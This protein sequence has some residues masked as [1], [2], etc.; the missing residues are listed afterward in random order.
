MSV[1]LVILVGRLGK[2]P[3]LTYTQSG[4]PRCRFSLATSESYTNNAGER[5]EKTDWHNIICWG[6]QAEPVSK[7]L[8]KGKEC[9]I[10]GKI[11][12][13]SWDDPKS[14][15]KKYMTEINAKRVVFLGGGGAKEAYQGQDDREPKERR[16][17][18]EGSPGS[19][20]P[21]SSGT[22]PED[23]SGIPF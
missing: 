8:A 7:Y 5:Q 15:Q 17:S 13:R 14:G 12:N 16:P 21:S 19:A 23:D 4:T 2:D 1:N 3:E 18:A 20:G 22:G 9:Y 6:K 10:E 11:E